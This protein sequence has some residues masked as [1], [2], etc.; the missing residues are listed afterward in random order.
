MLW[1]CEYIPLKVALHHHNRNNSAITVYSKCSV[2]YVIISESM[3]PISIRAFSMHKIESKDISNRK[4]LSK[5][6]LACRSRQS[7]KQ[8]KNTLFL[9]LIVH[10]TQSKNMA[11]RT[12]KIKKYARGWDFILIKFML[13]NSTLS[14]YALANPESYKS[15]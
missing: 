2:V 5:T 13:F 4:Y 14:T 9:F 11:T 10:N 7:K 1:R 3:V 15:Y 12:H 6:I 8:N